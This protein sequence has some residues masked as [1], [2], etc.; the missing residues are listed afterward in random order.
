MATKWTNSKEINEMLAK[1][2]SQGWRIEKGKNHIKAIP[3]DKTRPI[4][5]LAA[6]PSDHRAVMNVRAQ[7][8]RSGAV[9]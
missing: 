3:A 9:L 4:V 8:R 5:V 6:T 2:E 7:L 1:V